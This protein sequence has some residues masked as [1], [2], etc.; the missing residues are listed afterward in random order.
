[1]TNVS[2]VVYEALKTGR[3]QLI[4]FMKLP[5]LI[6]GSWPKLNNLV[7]MERKLVKKEL[8]SHEL[9]YGS[10]KIWVSG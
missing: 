8:N 5:R 6:N 3:S 4:R 9:Y 7:K 1:M 2:F 10:Q